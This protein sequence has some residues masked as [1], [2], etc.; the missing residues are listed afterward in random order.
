MSEL[1]F[2]QSEQRGRECFLEEIWRV[3][4]EQE[5]GGRRWLG[6]RSGRKRDGAET[7]GGGGGGGGM[8]QEAGEIF[9][10]GVQ[11]VL[12]AMRFYIDFPCCLVHKSFT[13]ASKYSL[14]FF[15]VLLL[16]FKIDVT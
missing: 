9:G 14:D 11:K 1:L 5:N 15:H 3:V 12:T 7:G 16:L 8:V 13:D 2:F 10:L 4:G 6:Q